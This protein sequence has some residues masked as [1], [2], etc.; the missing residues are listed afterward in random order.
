MNTIVDMESPISGM[1]GIL[2]V[3]SSGLESA[4]FTLL[5]TVLMDAPQVLNSF[6]DGLLVAI[7][8]HE[9]GCNGEE[10]DILHL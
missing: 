10:S 1:T 4:T 8:A 2:V 7:L 6:V 9:C 3:E 5:C